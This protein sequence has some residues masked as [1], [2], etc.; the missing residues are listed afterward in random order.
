[1][2]LTEQINNDIKEAMKAREKE[3]LEALRAIKSALLLEATKE[4]ASEGISAETEQN[5]LLKLHK[6]RIEAADIYKGQNRAD[7]A[8]VELNQA[9]IIEAY[10]PKQLSDSELEAELKQI[11]ADA[12]ASGAKDMGK[13]MGL[14]TPKLK[15]RA[16]G[17]RISSM[18]KALLG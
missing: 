15:G 17:K 10:L 12:A 5:L 11:I 16:D 13:V 9:A 7:L 2:N 14:A 6:Q 8:D 4:G 3:K 1:M 18:V